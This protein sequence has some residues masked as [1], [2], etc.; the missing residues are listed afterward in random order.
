MNLA[1]GS[2]TQYH[3]IA[4]DLWG[5][6]DDKEKDMDWD[7]PTDPSRFSIRRTCNRLDGKN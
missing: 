5:K 3:H 6:C 2:E 1:L 7:L 4:Q